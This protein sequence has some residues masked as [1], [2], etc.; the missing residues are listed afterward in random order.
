MP[1]AVPFFCAWM[2]DPLRVASVVPSSVA[3]ARAMTAEISNQTG[4]VIELGPGTGVF[5]RALLARGV[6]QRQLVLVERGRDF[7]DMMRIRFPEARVICADAASLAHQDLDPFERPGATVSGLPLLSMAPAQV[8]A[9]L[10]GAF[11]HMRP[12]GAFYQF[13]YGPRCPVSRRI[14]DLLDLEAES[15]GWVF[16]NFP[17]AQVYRLTRRT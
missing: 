7:A 14:R 16:R 2:S 12:G 4:P 3:L 6:Q 5:T 10:D 8:F 13:T 15:L 17:P 9:I 1:D 11:R